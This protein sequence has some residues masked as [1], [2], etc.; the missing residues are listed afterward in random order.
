MTNG[1]IAMRRGMAALVMALGAA[2]CGAPESDKAP[3]ATSTPTSAAEQTPPAVPEQLRFTAKTVDGSD[4]DGRSLAGAD[5]VVWF[6]APW[7]SDCRREAPHVA[8][9]QKAHPDVTFVGVAG[10]GELP[11]MQ[12]FVDDYGVDG[13]THLADLNGSLWKRFGVVRQPATAF[14]DDSGSIE[15]VRGE[16]GER[17]LAKQLARL[18]N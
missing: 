7:C 6:W 3:R 8:A 11:A 15:V 17:G 16:L 1:S 12:E 18:E 4:F 14:I 9:A 13:F 2:A 5:V 10:L